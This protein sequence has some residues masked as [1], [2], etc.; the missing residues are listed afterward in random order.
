VAGLGFLALE[1]ITPGGFFFLFFGLGAIGVG[2]LAGLGASG[3]LWAQLLLF[4]VISVAALLLFREKLKDVFQGSQTRTSGSDIVGDVVV[5]MA[6]L[7]PGGIGKAELRGSTWNVRS[8]EPQPLH[9]G[10]RCRVQRIE[11]LTLWVSAE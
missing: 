8:D 10:Q 1:M 4:P 5:L 7:V 9:K 11:G 6:D 2:V 3:P